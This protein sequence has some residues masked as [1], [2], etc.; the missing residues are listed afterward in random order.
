MAVSAVWRLVYFL[1]A[2]PFG[3]KGADRSTQ[4][5]RAVPLSKNSKASGFW[6]N[7]IVSLKLDFAAQMRGAWPSRPCGDWSTF[8]QPTH[9]EPKEQTAARRRDALCPSPKNSKASGFWL[10]IGRGFPK[11][12]RAFF[13][14]WPAVAKKKYLL[15]RCFWRSPVVSF[16]ERHHGLFCT[17]GK[18]G[19][20]SGI[21]IAWRLP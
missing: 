20:R 10:K 7:T 14:R 19:L 5:R 11:G 15:A 12:G 17:R 16:G 9:L 4:A 6:C 21:P 18:D 13:F 1:A 3:T 8:S 2:Y